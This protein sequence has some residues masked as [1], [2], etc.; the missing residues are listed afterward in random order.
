LGATP[1]QVWSMLV[2]QAA[3]LGA[4]GVVIGVGAAFVMTPLAAALLFGI[5]PADPMTF[6]GVATLLM[7][8]AVAAGALPARRAMRVDPATALRS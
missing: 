4:I 8:I 7:F 5:S 3:A 6:I 2:G 1:G